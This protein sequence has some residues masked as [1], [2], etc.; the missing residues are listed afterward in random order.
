MHSLPAVLKNSERDDV[1]YLP[2]NG[3]LSNW[4]RLP[5][6]FPRRHPME[7][8]RDA[9]SVEAMVLGFRG[10]RFE[11]AR[12]TVSAR[13]HPDDVVFKDVAGKVMQ[14]GW[15]AAPDECRGVGYVDSEGVGHVMLSGDRIAIRFASKERML[16]RVLPDGPI[17]GSLPIVSQAFDLDYGF[18]SAI[19]STAAPLRVASAEAK[20]LAFEEVGVLKDDEKIAVLD[21]HLVEDVQGRLI[22]YLATPFQIQV[23]G[24]LLRQRSGDV[25]QNKR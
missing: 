21:Q 11:E 10:F 25:W 17:F 20:L 19:L 14:L 3:W 12:G 18:T 23:K 15:L 8:I 5:E 6:E 4:M 1:L 7:P 9:G 22:D 24:N 16:L 2:K 13:M